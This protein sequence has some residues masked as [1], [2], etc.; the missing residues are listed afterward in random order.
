MA[1][2]CARAFAVTGDHG[3]ARR[4]RPAASSWFLGAN[5]VGVPVGDFDRGAGYDGLERRRRQ[6]QRGHRVDPRADHDAATRSS[7]GRGRMTS[8]SLARRQAQP[9]RPAA[10]IRRACSVSCSC[11]GHALAG[12]REGRASSTV[13][14]VLGADRRRRRGRPRRDHRAVRRPPPGSRR[15]VRPSRRT[16][17]QPGPPDVELSEQR[18]LLLGATFTQEYAVEAAAVCNPSAVAAPDQGGLA[19]GEL[20]AVLSVRQIGEGHRSSIG[21]RSIVVGERRRRLDR[22]AASPYTTAGTIEDVELDAATFA[23]LATDVDAESIRWVLDRLGTTLHDAA[24]CA[25]RLR[26]ARGPTG[27]A[28]RRVAARRRGCSSGRRAATP[29]GSR[30]LVRARRARAHPG[31]RRRVERSRGRPVRA[32]RRRR[33]HRH[34]LRDLHRLRRSRRSPSS[35]SPRPTSRRSPRPRCSAPV[36]P[37]RASRSSRDASAAATTP[38][39]DATASATRSPCPTTSAT[40]RRRRRST[41]PTQTWSSV[42]LGNCGSPI[43]LAEGWLV[44]THGVGAMRTYS[45]GALLLDIDDPSIVIGQTAQPADH[46]RPRRPGRLRPERRLLVRRA[47]PRR[48]PRRPV[49]HRRQPDRVRHALH[50]RRPRRHGRRR[51]RAARSIDQEVTN[52]A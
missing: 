30:V 4:P 36:P 21:F 48:P 50:L 52:D 13:A 41:S 38:C 16:P 34:L 32:L 49:R 31:L 11:P 9:G 27:H 46:P 45:I 47:P 15:D 3:L 18:R 7:D 23:G 6:P 37:T 25:T 24:S 2:A 29:S 35:S 40:G 8:S 33:R 39:P 28:P 5:D 17:R 22:L 44:L 14:H 1:D 10:R 12:E 51:R 43:E 26:R 19:P 20:R 42:Q